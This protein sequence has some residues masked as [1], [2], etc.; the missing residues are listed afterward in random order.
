VTGQRLL[1]RC[2][3]ERANGG[4]GDDQRTRGR[5]QQA[6]KL[7]GLVEQAGADQDRE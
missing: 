7:D 6:S 4:V 3:V 2:R 5:F 1:Q